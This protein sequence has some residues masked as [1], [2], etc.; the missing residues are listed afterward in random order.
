MHEQRAHHEKSTPTDSAR[1]GFAGARDSGDR[2]IWLSP[3]PMRPWN[4]ADRAVWGTALIEVDPDC[5]HFLE[6]LP[7][8]LDMR[9]TSL[10]GPRTVP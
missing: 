4:H 10:F 6:D 3:R 1:N 2:S 9:D 8:W 5:E 7:R